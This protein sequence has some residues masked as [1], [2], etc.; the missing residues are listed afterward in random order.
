[1]AQQVA[2]IQ[3]DFSYLGA[4]S[5]S[6]AVRSPCSRSFYSNR[7]FPGPLDLLCLCVCFHCVTLN[8]CLS[9][10]VCSLWPVLFPAELNISEKEVMVFPYLPWYHQFFYSPFQQLAQTSSRRFLSSDWVLSLPQLCYNSVFLPYVSCVIRAAAW[11]PC[12]S[13]SLL[14][15]PGWGLN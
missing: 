10:P 11:L 2:L 6:S 15:V 12:A 3:T 14:P 5:L 8:Q 13:Q 4:T 7:S 9:G 1:M